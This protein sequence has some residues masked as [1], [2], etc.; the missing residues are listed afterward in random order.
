MDDDEAR[1]SVAFDTVMENLFRSPTS[2]N[3]YRNNAGI[4]R[5]RET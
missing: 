1:V 3:P 2:K 5:S 4:P